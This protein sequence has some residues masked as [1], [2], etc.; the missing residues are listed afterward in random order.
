MRPVR[1]SLFSLEQMVGEAIDFLR[2][3]EPPEGYF[4]GFS[5]GKDSI[6]TLEL[7]RMA[8]VRHEA[9][10]SCT[11]I[12][13]PEIYK[14]IRQHYPTVKWAYPSISFWDGIRRNSPPFT[15]RRWCCDVLKKNPVKHIPL[16]MRVFGIRAEESARR[17]ARPRVAKVKRNTMLKPIF[18]WSEWHVWEFIESNSLAYPSLYDRGF[19]R[20]GCV[21]C[22]FIMGASFSAQAKLSRLRGLYP[23]MYR[24][25]EQTVS[26]WYNTRL[27]KH[28]KHIASAD[29]YLK[30][31]YE[32]F[33]RLPADALI[34]LRLLHE[35]EAAGPPAS[36]PG[37]PT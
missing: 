4:V 19:T 14:F 36:S 17:A 18:N 11:R 37:T 31:Y 9:W 8:G 33:E 21:I 7:C 28:D 20:I 25:F 30:N 1:V 24:L 6:C 22:P 34:D 27:Y 32:A 12:D 10:Y 29:E 26:D 35:M 2:A 16:N 13:P 3:H 5:G 23:K 15:Y